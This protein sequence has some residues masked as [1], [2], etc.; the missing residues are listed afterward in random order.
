M[1]EEGLSMRLIMLF[2]A[3]SF[4]MLSD[5]GSAQQKGEKAQPADE[6]RPASTNVRGAQYPR[7]HADRRVTFQLKAPDAKKVQLQPGGADNGLGKGPIDMIRGDSGLWSVT[8]QPAVPGFHYYWFLVDG[9]IANDPSSETF[10]GWG[11]QT[12]GVEVPETGTDFHEPK[13]VPHG[14]VRIFWYKSA[15]TGT[16]RRAYVY[17]P[18]DYDSA[19]SRRYP[20]LY[21]QHGAGEDERGWSTQGRMNFIVDNLIA[22]GKARPLIV[23]MDQGYAENMKNFADVFLKDLIPAVDAKYRTKSDRANRAMAG[24]SMGGGQTFQIA[25]TNLDK[26]SH[27]GSFSGAIKGGIDPKSSYGGVFN[28]PKLFNQKVALLYLH[29]GSGET[30]HKTAKAAHEGLTK[31]GINSVFVESQG[32]SHEWHTWRRALHD[33]VPRLFQQ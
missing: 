19:P 30:F 14:E 32:T 3:S 16:W 33:F 28:D 23:V 21:L 10:F 6:S 5:A 27:I 17:T 24:L 1:P 15:V 9:A 7:I 25:L 31:A 11:R 18:P 26:F 22:A 2:A 20:V 29:A 4:V 13:D 8:T 12:S